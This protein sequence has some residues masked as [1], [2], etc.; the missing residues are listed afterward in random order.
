MIWRVH[1][2][3][4]MATA[5]SPTDAARLQ[6]RQ[7]TLVTNTLGM[8]LRYVPAGGFRMGSSPDAA[9][10]NQD[11]TPAHP[12][13]VSKGFYLGQTEVTRKQFAAF[14]ADAVWET[15]AERE[16]WSYAWQRGAFQMVQGITYRS[17]GFPQTDNHPV[18][19]V[20]WHDAVE[21]CRW[22]GHR[23]GRRYRLPTEAEWEYA[24]RAGT[25]TVYHWGDRP[26]DGA[27]W[28]NVADQ[29]AKAEFSK[30]P[31]PSLLFPWSD[32]YVFTAPVG[33]FRPNAFG[34]YD[35]HGNVLE[36]CS[37]WYG[38]DYYR[39]SPATNPSGP[40]S[41]EFRVLRGGDWS[42]YPKVCRAAKR[43]RDKPG[44]RCSNLGFR[45]V[46]ELD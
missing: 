38:Q 30:V 16:G 28:C 34:L 43:Y 14:M 41:G 3:L 20:S 21:F 25:E 7:P 18:V 17:P 31:S 2:L 23:E 5:I 33:Q 46:L 19:C 8:R 45:V 12:V 27:G 42:S 35:M 9:M 26:E 36:F 40:K 1:I 11:E 13:R 15:Q 6:P 39:S 4:L 10:G 37:D 24:C 22:L 32:G 44:I 29:S